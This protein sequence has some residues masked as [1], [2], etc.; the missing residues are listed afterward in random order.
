MIMAL[1]AHTGGPGAVPA[2]R[3][4]GRDKARPSTSDF[5]QLLALW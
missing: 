3:E 1:A 5:N 2:V 4:G